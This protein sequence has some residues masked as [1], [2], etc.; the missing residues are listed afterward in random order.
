MQQSWQSANLFEVQGKV[1]EFQTCKVTELEG[2]P[3]RACH[4]SAETR[5]PR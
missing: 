5:K 4:V 3:K 2:C 1:L